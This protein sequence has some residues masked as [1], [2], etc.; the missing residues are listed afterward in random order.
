MCVEYAVVCNAEQ[1][2]QQSGC[3]L[4]DAVAE[5]SS[6]RLGDPWLGVLVGTGS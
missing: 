6:I 3:D 4:R 5:L 1:Q 2:R